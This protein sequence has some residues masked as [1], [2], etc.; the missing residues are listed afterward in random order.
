M[1]KLTYR[2][3]RVARLVR[4]RPGAC[5]SPF[6]GDNSLET[7]TISS[8]SGL[9]TANTFRM[10]D[11]KCLNSGVELKEVRFTRSFYSFA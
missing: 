9:G 1:L 11:W 3:T 6:L 7:R 5:G 4:L 2:F 10:T 8:N